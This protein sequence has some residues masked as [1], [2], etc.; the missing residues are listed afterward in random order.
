MR[1][2]QWFKKAFCKIRGKH[3]FQTV[4]ASGAQECYICGKIVY[5]RPPSIPVPDPDNTKPT[6]SGTDVLPWESIQWIGQ[7]NCSQALPTKVLRSVKRKGDNVYIDWDGNED[8]NAEHHSD[9]EA[10]VDCY[11]RMLCFVVRNGR[12]IGGHVDHMRKGCKQR[13]LNNV[14]GEYIF[15]PPVRSE[16]VRYY[17]MA[18]NDKKNRTNMVQET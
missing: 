18:S 15:N 1:I 5:P 14:F 12:L 6:P 7:A 2:P 8:W 9:W 17:A 16:E 13:D 11:G 3:E 4:S 10:G